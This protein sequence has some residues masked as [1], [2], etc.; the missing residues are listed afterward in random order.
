MATD[1]TPVLRKDSLADVKTF[2]DALALLSDAGIDVVSTTEYG[3]GFV[4]ERNLRSLVGIDFVILD[5][6]FSTGDFGE[7]VILRIVTTDDRK[8]IITD[9]S[10]GIC[11][12]MRDITSKAGR[13][14]GFAVKGGL[15]ESN[16]RFNEQTGNVVRPGEPGYEQ[17]KPATTYYLTQ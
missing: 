10:T 7:F 16:F 2:A 11:Q 9:G 5:T 3:D 8:L 6:Q 15:V 17:G 4:M 14:T 13:T 12:Q 1:S